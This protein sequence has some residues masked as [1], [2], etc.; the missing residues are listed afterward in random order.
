MDVAEVRVNGWF[1]IAEGFVQFLIDR[2]INH[3]GVVAKGWGNVVGAVVCE[4]GGVHVALPRGASM[5]DCA[6][7]T[8][9][10]RSERAVSD[11]WRGWTACPMTE[12]MRRSIQS[13]TDSTAGGAGDGV[14]NGYSGTRLAWAEGGPAEDGGPATS[15]ET[16]ASQP[17]S[18]GIPKGKC[19]P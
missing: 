18:V 15:V 12:P 8:R 17:E 1:R 16:V 3:C 9:A 6:R 10:I 13:S 4:I 11:C 2:G 14:A 7:S 5:S 19:R